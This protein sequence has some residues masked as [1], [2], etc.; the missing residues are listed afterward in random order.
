MRMIEKYN[1]IV[2]K[3]VK[4]YATRHYLELYEEE[5][6]DIS[7]NHYVDLMDYKWVYQ[8]PVNINDEYYSLDD[9]ILA[10]HLQI[11]CKCM[12]DYNARELERHQEGK[13]KDCNLFFYWMTKWEK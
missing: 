12:Q 9:I 3:I 1:E 10:E 6:D 11:P 7:Y 13:E 2:E 5:I 8:W 4:Q